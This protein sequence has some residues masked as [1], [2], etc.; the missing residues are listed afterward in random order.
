MPIGGR[1][2]SG[3]DPHKVDKCGVLRARQVAKKLVRRRVDEAH[4]ILGWGADGDA[5]VLI[6]ASTTHGGVSLHAPR[7]E[8]PP[9]EWFTI[10]AIAG[11]L[12]LP[13]RDWAADPQAGLFLSTPSS[14]ER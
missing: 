9:D 11:D 2:L 8:L 14:W 10:K 13:E 1:T 5:A 6:E 7:E 3:K 12:E 4:V